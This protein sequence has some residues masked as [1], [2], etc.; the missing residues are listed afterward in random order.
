MSMSMML[1]C[2][3]QEANIH[4]LASVTLPKNHPKFKDKMKRYGTVSHDRL[5]NS[6]KSMARH[7]FGKDAVVKEKFALSG[8]KVYPGAKMFGSLQLNFGSNDVE[9]ALA[10]GGIAE[11][12]EDERDLGDPAW[13]EDMTVEQENI[14]LS[15]ENDTA[16]RNF[17]VANNYMKDSDEDGGNIITIDPDHIYPTIAFRNSYDR[18]MSVGMALGYSVFICDNLCLSGEINYSRKHTINAFPD[19]V[20][21][22]WSLME[23]MRAQHEFDLRWKDHAKSVQ[24]DEIDGY[25]LMGELVGR[26]VLSLQG[27]DKS[28][29]AAAIKQWRDPAHEIFADRNL[30]SFENALTWAQHR[31][32]IGKRMESSNKVIS[33]L[34][35]ISCDD[36]SWNVE[37]QEIAQGYN[38]VDKATVLDLI[39]IINNYEKVE[40]KEE[41]L[42]EVRAQNIENL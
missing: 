10:D 24:I 12:H 41:V 8:G 28:Q 6:I 34:R 37:A 1:H 5:V 39:E 27:G 30:W 11:V 9:E 16:R 20:M 14:Y 35:S 40:E 15:M 3:S 42:V 17:L 22:I 29:F 32:H 38:K 21:T 33:T 26:D 31:S 36:D 7:A 19:A 23:T 18:S 25:R 13:L 4:D 2:G